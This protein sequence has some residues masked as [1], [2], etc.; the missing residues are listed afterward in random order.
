MDYGCLFLLFGFFTVAKWRFYI[1]FLTNVVTD[2]RQDYPNREIQAQ[3]HTVLCPPCQHIDKTESFFL[4]FPLLLAT[5]AE[6]S[7]KRLAVV[8]SQSGVMILFHDGNVH[9]ICATV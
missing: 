5:L 1:C 3:R 4:N 9:D 8:P 7:V 6:D 2:P